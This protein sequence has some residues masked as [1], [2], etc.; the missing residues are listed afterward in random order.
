[1]K[2][3]EGWMG[4]LARIG[5][6][7][8][9]KLMALTFVLVILIGAAD[10]V[11]GYE[12]S[13]SVFY[14]SAVC[15]ATWFIGFRFALVVAIGSVA[16]WFI[17]DWAAGAHYTSRFVLG[18]NAAIALTFYWVMI[19]VLSS[20]RS[21]QDKLEAKVRERTAALTDEMATNERLEKE[22]LS[23]S[24]REQRRIGHDLHDSLCQ[25]LTGTALA[26]H[27]LGEKLAARGMPEIVD[28]NR[29]V[30]LVEEGISLARSLARGLAPVEL[31]A[32]GLMAAFRELAK[33]TSE[34]L[35]IDCR[36]ESSEPVLIEDADTATHLFRIA[37]EA[38]SNAIRHGRA[39]NV[40]ISLIHEAGRVALRV[41]DD[42]C[43]LPDILPPDR[44][45]GLHI[46]Q[47]RA[48]MIGAR[49]S[50]R[51]EGQGTLVAC[52]LP[53]APLTEGAP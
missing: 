43:G 40:R 10:Y 7:S 46:M 23:I 27:V 9:R 35:R 25:H 45:M 21:L 12:I 30:A 41:R 16:C 3:V 17:G 42:G 18:W 50:I 2:V 5:R 4:W 53:D 15:L 29:V 26:G 34:R 14:L 19:A 13:F 11:T 22:L 52:V 20:L 6:Q 51:R 28:A 24:E 1:M 48:A 36:F 31:E 33:S 47:H 49:F 37:Q 32:E 38:I 39:Q 8:R 44:G